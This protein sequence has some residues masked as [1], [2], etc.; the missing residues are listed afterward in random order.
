M[1]TVDVAGPAI[2]RRRHQSPEI[3]DVD[4]FEEP[5]ISYIGRRRTQRGP[6]PNQSTSDTAGPSAGPSHS[7][8]APII[9]LDSD[10]ES[11]I[12][13][14]A[15]TTRGIP[16]SFHAHLAH[17]DII[18]TEFRPRFMSPPPR[19]V[20]PRYIPPVP[21][22][23]H[24]LRG[25]GS[26]PTHLILQDPLPPVIRPRAQPFPFEAQF[27]RPPP[28]GPSPP[29]QLPP[30][31]VARSHHQPSMGLG[32]AMIA[33]NR[34]N[35]VAEEANR[36]REQELR[37]SRLGPGLA[38]GAARFVDMLA[39][40]RRALGNIA[41]SLDLD[42]FDAFFDGLFGAEDIH[43]AYGVHA[44]APDTA[45][46]GPS[47]PHYK[48][49][50]THPEKAMPGFTFDFAPSEVSSSTSSV[51]I[52][53]DNDGNG[54]AGPSTSAAM[55]P[56]NVAMTMSL[57]CAHCMDPLV[58]PVEGA[59][60]EERK[61]KRIWAL[62]CGHMFDG[63]C[64]ATL[65]RPP[66][67]TRKDDSHEP[68]D[69]AQAKLDPGSSSSSAKASSTATRSRGRRKPG[70]AADIKGKGKMVDLPEPDPSIPGGFPGAIR[71]EPASEDNSMRSR[72]RSHLPSR[73]S[74]SVTNSNA[75][76]AGLSNSPARPIRPLPR[77]RGQNS[78]SL[79]GKGKG[80]VNA[81]SKAVVTAIHEWSCPVAGCLRVHAS[82]CINGEW[83]MD[84]DRGGI[85]VYV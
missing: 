27:R 61:D 8:S 70:L 50:Y 2:L 29:V 4:A 44:G 23:P 58:R 75:E 46:S 36:L 11:R 35:A 53:E 10:D 68:R 17:V 9:I 47:E 67:D 32:G 59:S 34:Q 42:H 56:G 52:V 22:I 49:F 77:R 63:K 80:R 38:A 73:A 76:A 82:V 60:D 54:V 43:G 83:K 18:S 14:A 37:I 40:P 7:G 3:I 51:T 71:T 69:E 65:M 85:V 84:K 41:A 72:L 66:A 39:G 81:K 26:F 45:R 57:V 5:E 25:Q 55:A 20:H 12:N 16:R 31:G 33:L 74:V 13:N 30:L 64:T 15:S 19:P 62:R 28:R 21:P 79:R 24:N 48:P 6:I 78:A 1:A